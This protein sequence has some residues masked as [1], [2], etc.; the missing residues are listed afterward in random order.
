[1]SKKRRMFDIDLPQGPLADPAET[2]P[3]GKVFDPPAPGRRGPM[4]AAIAETADSTRERNAI[5]AQIRAE[6]D[7]LAHEHVRLKRLGLVIELIPLDQIDMYKLVRDRTKGDDFELAELMASLT[8]LG[9][10]NPIRLEAR[11]DGR[12]ELIQGYRRLSAYRALL[13]ET[14]DA[15]RWAA[16]PAA[17]SQPGDSLDALYRRMVDENLIRKDISFAEMAQLAVD[18]A[19]EPET[20]VTDPEKAVA[21]LFKSAGYQKRSYIRTFIKVVEH[22]GKDLHFA[23]DIP[24]A[25]GMALAARLEEVE[26]L[27][28][29]IRAELVQHDNRSV[30]E[31]LAILRRFAGQRADSDV[32]PVTAPDAST[33]PA[34]SAPRPAKARTSFQFDRREGRGKCVA[35]DGKLE[36]QLARDFTTIDRRRLEQAVR[37]LLDQ[38]EG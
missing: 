9:L 8:E 12:F 30:A 25:L 36:I 31:E 21:Q 28:G 18:Y 16:I 33:R 29:L 15:D 13:A 3:A 1:M 34:S 20:S 14:G 26:G 35:A 23:S 37:L 38:L 2:F 5:E 17:V 4:A 7:A 24:R 19:A 10:S 27:G 6:N 11:A 22:L 32:A